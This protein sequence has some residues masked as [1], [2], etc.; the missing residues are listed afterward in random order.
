MIYILQLENLVFLNF[1]LS[2]LAVQLQVREM[3]YVEKQS[4]EYFIF[5]RVYVIARLC[6]SI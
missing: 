2:A 6:L 4:E 5:V 3:I 1:F